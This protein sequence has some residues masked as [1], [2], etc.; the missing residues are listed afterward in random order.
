[1]KRIFVGLLV[2]VLILSF[3]SCGDVAGN[4]IYSKYL[5]L[6]E[7]EEQTCFVNQFSTVYGID[8]SRRTFERLSSPSADA[9]ELQSSDRIFEYCYFAGEYSESVPAECEWVRSHLQRL[10]PCDDGSVIYV[11]AENYGAYL[12]GYV[13]VYERVSGATGNYAV[14]EIDYSVLF[15]YGIETDEFII[16]DRLEDAVVVAVG[17]DDAV[18]W[19]ECAYD[20]YDNRTEGSVFLL[21]DPAYDAGLS[22]LSWS[23]ALSNAEYCILHFNVSRTSGDRELMYVLEYETDAFYELKLTNSQK[24]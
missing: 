16:T 17:E 9:Q 24:N 10:F 12:V 4:R 21:E 7:I 1:M 3:A 11:W 14:E 13:Q 8:L 2:I 15:R 19:K 5:Q 23:E 20:R 18:Y 22:Q 6:A